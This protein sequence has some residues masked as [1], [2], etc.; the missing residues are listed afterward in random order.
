MT[1]HNET[2]RVEHRVER[3]FEVH[4]TPEQVWDAIATTDGIATW[5]APARLDPRVGGE[6]SFDLDGFIS[7]GVVTGY[8]PN[9]RFAYEEPWPIADNP[10]E[11]PE[12][13]AEWFASIG[14][15]LSR[16]YADVASISPIATEFLVESQSGGTCVLRVVSS[17]YGTGAEWEHEF[18]AQMV[19]GWG[20]MLDNLAKQ[21]DG[22]VPH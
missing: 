14:V 8:S 15:P 10:A 6:V 12:D 22:P 9:H 7:T 18:F 3:R 2:R 19:E 20:A 16:V 11:L 13:M 17:A 5:M 1:E 4:A 21:L